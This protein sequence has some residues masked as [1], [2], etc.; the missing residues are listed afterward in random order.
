PRLAL[1]GGDPAVTHLLAWA[2]GQSAHLVAYAQRDAAGESAELLVAPASRRQGLAGAMIAALS[3]GHP[4]LRWWA[5]GD[6][7]AA[8]ATAD[9]LGFSP[10][11]ELWEMAAQ[12]P[13]QGT[14]EDNRTASVQP[15]TP[16]PAPGG[17]TIRRFQP[18]RDEDAWVELNA[19][20]FADH[21]EQGKLTRTDLATRM[22]QDWFDPDGFFLLEAPGG[23]LVG[24]IW[25]KV[26]RR[27]PGP[28]PQS[29]TQAEAASP[30]EGEV[31]AIG[32]HPTA[33]GRRLGT[34]LLEHG[35][36]YLAGGGIG[37]LV[38]YVE[39]DNAPAIAAYRHQG[40]Q[41]R[42][43][44]VQYARDPEP[45]GPDPGEDQDLDQDDI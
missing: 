21:P 8:R 36:N 22:A 2:D 10:V 38:L 39:A 20:A 43:R 30:L 26:E 6:L 37:H 3:E 5:H 28:G 12:R 35:L 45:A 15:A 11:R 4:G 42:Q 19:I 31:Y 7:P 44:H 27:L 18:G 17:H 29:Q 16:A 13:A 32:L 9:A 25:T 33:Q 41:V 40:F 34:A 24:Y 23:S 14:L 1:A